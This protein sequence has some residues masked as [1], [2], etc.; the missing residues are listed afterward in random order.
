MVRSNPIDPDVRLEK[1][2]E[3]LANAG[4]DILLLGWRRFGNASKMEMK[5]SYI[6]KRI[7][8]NAPIE[9]RVLLFLPIW[10]I[11]VFFQLIKED[12][13]I[14]HAADLDTYIPA[15][16]VTKLKRKKIVYDIFDFYADMVPLHTIIRNI[17]GGFEIFILKLADEVIIVDKSR[18]QQIH[19]KDDTGIHIIVNSP[20][21]VQVDKDYFINKDK[22]GTFIIF[23]AGILGQGRGLE[24]VIEAI[25]DF[26]DIQ[27]DIAGFGH[28]SQY[29]EIQSKKNEHIHFYGTISYE[30]VIQ[31]TLQSDLLFALYDPSI[32]NNRYSSPNK[33][34]EAMMTKKPILVTDKTSMANIVKEENCGLIVP[35][36]NIDALKEAIELLKN[37]PELCKTLGENGRNAYEKKYHWN[38]MEERL[39]NCYHNL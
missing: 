30:E 19:R 39:I 35:Y 21:E 16:I 22:K 36:G 4:Y 34:F 14:V 8:F 10:W 5:S 6:I 3:T 23:F 17:I 31:K 7:L 15:L 24:L 33:L 20:K 2:A 29:F 26:Q 38:I 32:P 11:L 28:Y 18:L 9:K 1:E 25:K 13:D 12:W 37:D 27:L